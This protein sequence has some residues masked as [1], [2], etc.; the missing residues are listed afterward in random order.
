MRRAEEWRVNRSG[1]R[2]FSED[3]AAIERTMVGLKGEEVY[4]DTQCVRVN[5]V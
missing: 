1:I 5:R 2:F 4:P 3:V